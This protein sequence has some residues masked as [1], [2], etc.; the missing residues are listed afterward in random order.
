[1]EAPQTG[2]VFLPQPDTAPE[3]LNADSSYNNTWFQIPNKAELK[4]QRK[5]GRNIKAKNPRKL[6][7]I[8]EPTPQCNS[9]INK[10]QLNQPC[11]ICGFKIKRIQDAGFTGNGFENTGVQCEHV[12]PVLIMAILFGLSCP[13]LRIIRQNYFKNNKQL[14]I[15][16]NEYYEWQQDMWTYAYKWSHTECNMIKNQ[17]PFINITV[18]IDNDVMPFVTFDYKG[19]G[20]NTHNI[21]NL[22]KILLYDSDNKWSEVWRENYYQETIDE[23]KAKGNN[24]N[25]WINDKTETLKNEMELFRKKLDDQQKNMPYFCCSVGIF[26]DILVE[27]LD[28]KNPKIMEKILPNSKRIMVL[29]NKAKS[30]LEENKGQVT[31]L[32]RSSRI[33]KQQQ[34]Q[35]FMGGGGAI[36]GERRGSQRFD[37]LR[38]DRDNQRTFESEDQPFGLLSVER[39]Q[40]QEENKSLYNIDNF[41]EFIQDSDVQTDISA[42]IFLLYL[43]DRDQYQYEV[44]IINNCMEDPEKYDI[45]MDYMKIF[46]YENNENVISQLNRAENLIKGTSSII[47]KISKRVKQIETDISGESRDEIEERP[48]DPTWWAKT[49]LSAAE[50]AGRAPAIYETD[51]GEET[52]DGLPLA[53]SH[54]EQY[55]YI[56]IVRP[57]RN[58]PNISRSLHYEIEQLPSNY[59]CM[60]NGN[61]MPTESDNNM[62]DIINK[63]F[64]NLFGITKSQSPDMDM[65]GGKIDNV[66]NNIK[67]RLVDKN[68]GIQSRNKGQYKFY[69]IKSKTYSNKQSKRNRKKSQKKTKRNRKKNQQKYKRNSKKRHHRR[70]LTK[71]KRRSSIRK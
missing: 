2:K 59:E 60:I 7:E 71:S 57:W 37:P 6:Y 22:F 5:E 12:I 14:P 67:D 51:P 41:M 69:N 29:I 28:C 1:M 68:S 63:S 18:N 47:D 13:K 70:S 10:V 8:C 31:E 33:Y 56:D 30:E 25:T 53:A 19:D 64:K 45:F 49:L 17:Y 61:S 50:W 54:P 34:A 15:K 62:I 16:E 39:Q 21:D 9:S 20:I 27:F 66:V 36:R 23:I 26:R 11:Y 48:V 65:D 40:L 44:N 42:A 32:R 43:S 52:A 38:G 3:N 46:Y 58:I 35:Q 24:H 55:E 4:Q